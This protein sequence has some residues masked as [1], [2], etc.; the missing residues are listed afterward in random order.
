MATLDA[1]RKRRIHDLMVKTRLTEETAISMNK[2]GEGHFWIGGAGEEAFGTCLGLQVNKGQGPD[3]DFLHLH[4]RGGPTAI[5]MGVE[6]IDHLRQMRATASDPFSGGRQFVEH[7]AIP[8]WNIVPVSPTIE[9]QYTMAPG[10]ALVQKR[11][12]GHGITIVTG[13]DAG[14]AEGDFHVC[15]T[16]AS[17]P[18]N[19]L[20]LLIIVTH[21]RWGI[22]TAS[23]SQWSTTSLNDLATPFGIKNSRVNGNDVEASW[24]AIAQ[25]MDYV[26]T[27]RRPY[28]LQ[29]DVSRLYGH[30]SAS[31]AN[32]IEGEPDCIALFEDQLTAEGIVSRADCDAV[33]D[34]WR[35]QIRSAYD[36][37]HREPYPDGTDIWKHIFAE[38]VRT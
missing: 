3:H 37:I 21:N 31:G 1:A 12:G 4:Y 32:R 33:W 24:D 11:H 25:A 20:P 23:S 6:P 13:G 34:R 8:E 38:P 10:T 22:S 18:G 15:L 14:A 17:R 30:S 19:E 27:E 5:A 26:R 35:D 28:C 9:T 29:A 16:W 2:K 36:Q 7:Y